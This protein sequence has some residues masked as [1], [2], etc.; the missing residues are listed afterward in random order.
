MGQKRVF[1]EN[2]HAGAGKPTV[3]R[4]RA[5][6]TIGVPFGSLYY[7]KRFVGSHGV[8]PTAGVKNMSVSKI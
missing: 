5:A 1:V 3:G 2:L 7:G 6:E 8:P 4:I